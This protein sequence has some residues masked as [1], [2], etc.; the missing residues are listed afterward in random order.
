MARGKRRSNFFVLALSEL[1]TKM[2]SPRSSRESLIAARQVA[3][4]DV[5]RGEP[6]KTFGECEEGWVPGCG[7]GA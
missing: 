7:R 5:G 1:G 3:S 4:E 6:W 2:A